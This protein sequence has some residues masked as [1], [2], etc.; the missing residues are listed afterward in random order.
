M[1]AVTSILDTQQRSYTIVGGHVRGFFKTH[2]HN[3][4]QCVV[5][6]QLLETSNFSVAQ[7]CL[8]VCSMNGAL[9][10]LP[11][12]WL[13]MA[14][15]SV[16]HYV[17]WHSKTL[18]LALGDD[19]SLTRI[20]VKTVPRKTSLIVIIEGFCFTMHDIRNILEVPSNVLMEL[21]NARVYYE[22]ALLLLGDSV[23]SET[24]QSTTLGYAFVLLKL[25][26]YSH[27]LSIL[28]VCTS[29]LPCLAWPV[30]PSFL[31]FC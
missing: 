8:S 31:T 27:M 28:E 25:G 24:R 22:N 29:A 7:Q 17:R 30:Y 12:L 5:G 18:K 11:M 3:M 26:R 14:E 2:F 23:S 4:S 19:I 1:S 16:Q 20:D 10:S 6:V 13:R 15:C 21:E 9:N